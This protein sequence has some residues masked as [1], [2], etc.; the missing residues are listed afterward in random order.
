MTNINYLISSQC[1]VSLLKI[2]YTLC[3]ISRI[4][5]DYHPFT[6]AKNQLSLKF[7]YSR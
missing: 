7:A 2:K 5:S 4:K 3:N 6:I 1:K